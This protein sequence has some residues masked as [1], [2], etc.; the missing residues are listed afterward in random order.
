MRDKDV[1]LRKWAVEQ[2]WSFYDQ[3]NRG[4]GSSGQGPFVPQPEAMGMFINSIYE[5]VKYGYT[6]SYLPKE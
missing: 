2:A 5:W 1:E 3:V 6:P 4:L